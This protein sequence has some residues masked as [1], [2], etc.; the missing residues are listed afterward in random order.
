M[1]T[2]G[3]AD[4]GWRIADSQSARVRFA[5][6]YSPQ[7]AARASWRRG[8]IGLLL[9][10]LSRVAFADYQIGAGDLL[11]IAVFG[12]PELSSEVRVSESGAIT[13]DEAMSRTTDPEDL[14]RTFQRGVSG[15]AVAE[16]PAA[17]AATARAPRSCARSRRT[18]A[19]S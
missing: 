1:L 17:A 7:F 13:Y 8:L 18:R 12:S 14:K 16:K 4:S 3:E 10:M 11:R 15:P 5:S 6:G 2:E 9:L 19:S